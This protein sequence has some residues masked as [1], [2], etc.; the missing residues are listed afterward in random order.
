[1]S[2][3]PDFPPKP[4]RPIVTIRDYIDA[5]M[6]VRS[7]CSSGKGHSHVVDLMALELARGPNA[8][9]DYAFKRSLTCPECGAA[10]GGLMVEQN[11]QTDVSG[12]PKRNLPT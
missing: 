3:V 6:K 10:G 7:F 9:I 2:R 1:M 5:G 11:G 4:I 8:E 12:Q